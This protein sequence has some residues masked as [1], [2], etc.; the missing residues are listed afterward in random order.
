M[1]GKVKRKYQAVG[2]VPKHNR[3]I[4]ERGKIEIPNTQMTTD[5]FRL[6]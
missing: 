1:L 3:E 2:P 5:M 4:V 6:S